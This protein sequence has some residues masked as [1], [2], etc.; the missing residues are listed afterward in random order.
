LGKAIDDVE[1]D[2]E[3]V[4]R[5]DTDVG[6]FDDEHGEEDDA[7]TDV[8]NVVVAVIAV[9]LKVGFDNVVDDVFA[10]L[11]ADDH[12]TWNQVHS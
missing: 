7:L 5:T 3:F 2:H 12:D 4:A 10:L 6:H 11:V 1:F 8:V 9:V